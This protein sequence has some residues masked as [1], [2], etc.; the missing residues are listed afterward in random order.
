MDNKICGLKEEKLKSMLLSRIE[1]NVSGPVPN[2]VTR[3]IYPQ[4][5]NSKHYLVPIRTFG[6]VTYYT[7][8]FIAEFFQCDVKLT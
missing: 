1:I 5:P 3:L 2:L 7:H 4:L 8:R 6:H